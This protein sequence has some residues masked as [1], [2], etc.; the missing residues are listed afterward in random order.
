MSTL[1]SLRPLLSKKFKNLFTSKFYPINV[2]LHIDFVRTYPFVCT[3]NWLIF[4]LLFQA[5]N[6]Y[7]QVEEKKFENLALFL[8]IFFFFS[9]YICTNHIMI[10]CF[11]EIN[12][13]FNFCYR[14][15]AHQLT[16]SLK[17]ARKAMM[18]WRISILQVLSLSKSFQY[19]LLLFPHFYF[20]TNF[21]SNYKR[22]FSRHSQEKELVI[23]I[24]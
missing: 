15:W 2:D 9:S 22:K 3:L 5:I 21:G 12:E 16:I 14:L 13:C 20:S 8:K 7:L 17:L 18:I 6:F 4:I 19:P 10:R 11:G 24:M 1:L 23:Y